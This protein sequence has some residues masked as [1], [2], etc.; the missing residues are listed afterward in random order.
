MVALKFPTFTLVKYGSMSW[1]PLDTIKIAVGMGSLA[2]EVLSTLPRQ[3]IALV[4]PLTVPVQ[5]GL[6]S[7]A[8]ASSAV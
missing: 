8:F 3:T 5:A 7:G 1:F 4:M 2:S 6:L